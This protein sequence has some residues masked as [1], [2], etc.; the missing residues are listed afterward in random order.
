MLC[1]HMSFIALV[2]QPKDFISKFADNVEA[3]LTN[4]IMDAS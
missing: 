3:R 4:Y 1:S 2:I